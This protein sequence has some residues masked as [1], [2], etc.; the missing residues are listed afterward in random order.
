MAAIGN[1]R[2]LRRK[3][4]VT[5]DETTNPMIGVCYSVREGGFGLWCGDNL[6]QA[7]QQFEQ[8]VKRQSSAVAQSPNY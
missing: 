8:A 2:I 6:A 3:R 4:R 1:H 7:E 5:L